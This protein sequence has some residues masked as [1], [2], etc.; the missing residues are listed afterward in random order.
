MATSVVPPSAK[1][2]RYRLLRPWLRGGAVGFLIVVAITVFRG[3]LGSNFHTVV[4]G[5]V[6]RSAQPT[7]PE[8]EEIIRDEGIRTVINL[9]G[10][11]PPND[12]YLDECRVTHKL[13]VAQEDIGLSA[14]RM[15]STSEVRRL[16]EVLDHC[17]YPV[18][19][20]CW[21]G[22]DRTGMASAIARLLDGDDTLE[23][24]LGELGIWYGHVRLGKT[25][26]IDRFFE[27]YSDWL[28]EQGVAHS[29]EAFRRWATEAYCPGECRCELELLHA[30]AYVW[31]GRPIALTLRA[32]NTSIKPWRLRPETNAGIHAT[33]AL[34]GSPSTPIFE[35]RA[36]MFD[37]K[38]PPGASIDLTLALPAIAHAGSYRLV[39]DMVDEQHCNFF[40]AGSD[41]LEWELEVRDQEI[42]T[43]R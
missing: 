3:T 17:E 33:F 18:L 22:A 1:S 25:A 29:P 8:L 27:L 16:I 24:A 14:M 9:R 30:P 26:Y 23:E 40:S 41:L 6:Y 20:H 34:Y 7:A 36:G 4:P 21:R 2:C 31:C 13:N 38:V 28:A 12:W 5:R 15:P 37:A 39:V 10:C 35:G 19:F 11:C 32:H 42:A 43:G